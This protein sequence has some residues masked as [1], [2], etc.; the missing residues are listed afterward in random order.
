MVYFDFVVGKGLFTGVFCLVILY[1]TLAVIARRC[2]DR[3]R[4]GWFQLLGL[5]PLVNIWVMIELGCLKGTSGDNKYGP[6]PL[7]V[8]YAR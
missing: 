3:N 2:H 7:T 8:H 1:P 5:I 6:D 4:S